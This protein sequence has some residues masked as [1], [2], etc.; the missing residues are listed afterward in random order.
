M[1][2]IK[3]SKGKYAV[4]KKNGKVIATIEA[5]QKLRIE[6]GNDVEVVSKTFSTLTKTEKGNL[7]VRK[8]KEKMLKAK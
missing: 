7:K 6:G 8:V 1:K 3:V 2:D 5:K 4:I